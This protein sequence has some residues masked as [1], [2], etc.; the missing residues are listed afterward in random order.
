MNVMSELKAIV[1]HQSDMETLWSVEDVNETPPVT[2]DM[3]RAALRH[4]HAVIEGD[5]IVARSAKH[6]YW[7]SP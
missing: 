1:D 2:E 5:D 7:D 6:H 3:L 4:L